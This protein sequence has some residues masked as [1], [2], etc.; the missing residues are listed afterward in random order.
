MTIGIT[1]QI[2]LTQFYIEPAAFFQKLKKELGQ[3]TVIE[4]TD[5]A[6]RHLQ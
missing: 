6:L 2:S 4:K 5:P 1:S 3:H